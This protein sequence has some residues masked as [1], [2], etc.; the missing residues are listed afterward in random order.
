[1]QRHAHSLS[2]PS[3]TNTPI[4]NQVFAPLRKTSRLNIFEDTK[5]DH[6]DSEH[7]QLSDVKEADLLLPERSFNMTKSVCLLSENPQMYQWKSFHKGPQSPGPAQRAGRDVPMSP[8]QPLGFGWLQMESPV[9][10]AKSV[11]DSMESVPQTS[12]PGW[13]VCSDQHSSSVLERSGISR[14]SFGEHK[15][16]KTLF[17]TLNT[18]EKSG[19]ASS[20]R[21]SHPIWDVPMNP[22]A[23]PGLNRICSEVPVTEAQAGLVVVMMSPQQSNKTYIIMNDLEI[24]QKLNYDAPMSPTQPSTP[25][26]V[27]G[28]HLYSSSY[29]ILTCLMISHV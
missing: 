24:S 6:V 22:C 11:T 26:P 19:C 29:R 2:Q 3:Q 18:V 25:P 23:E 21:G 13:T 8:E 20:S 17:P 10:M 5:P 15:S 12:G 16:E 1:M 28:T 7:S 14:R 4:N 9:Q 27:S